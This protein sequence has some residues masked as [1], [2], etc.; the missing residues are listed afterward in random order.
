MGTRFRKIRHDILS[1][2]VRTALVS[3]S[4]FIGVFGTVTLFSMG[5]LLVRQLRH[6][7]N[8]DQLAMV[9]VFLALPPGGQPDNAQM[10][11]T[12]RSQPDV[13]TVEG[14]AVY[15]ISWHKTDETAFRS[16]SVFARF[17]WNRCAW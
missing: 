9:R 8:Q 14:Q 11:A 4:I 17:S 15:P 7:L 6:D 3:M 2:K 10:L 13:T 1:R 16:S 12:L 5:D